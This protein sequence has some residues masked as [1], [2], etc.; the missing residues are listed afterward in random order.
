MHLAPC[1]LILSAITQVHGCRSL[2]GPTFAPTRRFHSCAFRR[3]WRA[4][5]RIRDRWWS[6]SSSRAS[7]TFQ[8]VLSSTTRTAIGLS[9]VRVGQN[10]GTRCPAGTASIRCTSAS[11]AFRQAVRVLCSFTRSYGPA[12]QYSSRDGR[13]DEIRLCISSLPAW[14]SA[15]SAV[16]TVADS[17]ANAFSQ[18]FARIAF[19][20]SITTC[21]CAGGTRHA[22]AAVKSKAVSRGNRIGRAQ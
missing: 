17:N 11:D 15:R 21:S 8:V 3:D 14:S 19:T 4:S 20:Y 9:S 12:E 6:S 2:R 13:R 10:P 16:C 7:C 22:V 18:S 5:C 1:L